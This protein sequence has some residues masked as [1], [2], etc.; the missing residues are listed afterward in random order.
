MVPLRYQRLLEDPAAEVA[1][2]AAP[3]G[4]PPDQTSQLLASP[5][6]AAAATPTTRSSEYEQALKEGRE[7]WA[8]MAPSYPAFESALNSSAACV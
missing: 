7:H 5:E 4:L 1:C 2:L 6:F 3:L 8:R